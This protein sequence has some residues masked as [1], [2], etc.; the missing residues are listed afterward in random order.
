MMLSKFGREKWMR[1][2]PTFFLV[3]YINTLIN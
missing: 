2:S 3:V 1:L